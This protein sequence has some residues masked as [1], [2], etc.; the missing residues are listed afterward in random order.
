MAY[1]F[2]PTTS[3]TGSL[4][5]S[6]TAAILEKESDLDGQDEST[7]FLPQSRSPTASANHSR[8]ASLISGTSPPGGWWNAV[9]RRFAQRNFT[10]RAL[11]VGMMSLVAILTLL[12]TL[13]TEGNEGDEETGWYDGWRNRIGEKWN[14]LGLQSQSEAKTRKLDLLKVINFETPQD[15]LASQLKS[16]VRY[17]TAMSYGGHANQMISI[18]KLLYFSKI[19]NRVPI[20]PSLIPVHIDGGPENISTFYNLPLF[21]HLTSL[22]ALEISQIKSSSFSTREGTKQ[23]QEEFPCWSIQESTVG[24]PNREAISFDMHGLYV[25]HWPLPGSGFA[26]GAGGFDLSF[27]ALRIWDSD[28]WQKDRWIEKVRREYL[29]QQ[30]WKDKEGKELEEIPIENEEERKKNIKDGFTPR[31]SP[32]PTDQMVAFDNS[33]FLGPIMPPPI[34]LSPDDAPL[35]PSLAGEGTSWQEI[36][37]YLRFTPLVESRATSYLLQLFSV[38]KPSQIPP[39]ITIHLRRGDFA[40]FTGAYTDLEKYTSALSRLL[41]R[42]QARLD[43]STSY[44]GPSRNAFRPPPHSRLPATEYSIVATTDESSSS[45]FVQKVKALGWKVVDHDEFKTKETFG[46]WWPTLLDC[47]ILARGRSFVGTDKST[48]TH[49]AALRVKYWNGG[50]VEIA[51]N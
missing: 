27:D 42:L 37:Q 47:A 11:A 26:R 12:S 6:S 19:T 18:Q 24:F 40:E 20:I 50:V 23:I 34:D 35:E 13:S 45:P 21:F 48:Y 4:T 15:T 16:G 30:Q 10:R 51:G 5:P 17:A 33:L 29:P 2:P 41:P 28:S 32:S 36:G 46:G 7:S 14:T 25:H 1:S 8:T 39:F 31:E 22:P 49:L 3:S 38:S 43:N 44:S 9:S